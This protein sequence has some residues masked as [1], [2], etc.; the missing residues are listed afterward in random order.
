VK[1]SKRKVAV[2][3]LVAIVSSARLLRPPLISPEGFSQAVFDDRGNLL[4]LTLSHD[5]KYRLWTPL[6]QISPKVIEA[7]L[8]EEDQYFRWHWG[9]NPLALVRATFRTFLKRDRRLGASTITMQLVRL[10]Q[11]FGTKNAYGKIRQIFSALWLELNYSKDKILEAYLNLVP[12]GLNVEGVGAASFIYFQKPPEKLNLAE[13]LSLVAIPQNPTLR[14]P[15]AG[16][17]NPSYLKTRDRLFKRW[18]ERDGHTG[19]HEVLGISLRLPRDLP[20]RAPHFVDEAL[21][22]FPSRP[23]IYTT[24]NSSFQNLLERRISGYIEQKKGRGIKNA[25]AMLLDYRTMEVKS[26][27]GSANFHDAEISGQVNGT[28]ALR[29]PGS[30]LKPFIYGL[31]IDQGLIHPRTM[32]KDTPINFGPDNPE[33]SDHDFIGP[34]SAHAALN[35]SRNLPA[36]W[37]SNRLKTPSLFQF[38]TRAGIH[39]P[40]DEEY[41]GLSLTL[42]GAEMTMEDLVRLYAGLV[43]GGKI[44]SIKKVQGEEGDRP[45]SVLSTQAAFLVLD[46]LK[47]NP[48]P[49]TGSLMASR[50]LWTAWKTGTSNGARDA[51]TLAVFGPYVLGV[52]VGN[53]DGRPNTAFTGR[54]AAA[55]LAFQIIEGLRVISP[56]SLE[57]PK[58]PP[59]ISHVRVC[60]TSGGLPSPACRRTSESPFIPGKSPITTCDIHREVEISKLTGL[61]ICP[62]VAEPHEKKVFEFWSSDLARLFRL[63]GLPRTRPPKLDQRCQTSAA[64]SGSRPEI[65]SPLKHLSYVI[66][67][68]ANKHFEQ[69]NTIP[70]TATSDG[71]SRL[72][73]WFVNERFLGESRN[74]APLFWKAEPGAYVVRVVDE[75]GRSDARDLQVTVV[76]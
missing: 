32:L 64:Q 76:D 71:D 23:R 14:S 28:K 2:V 3:S 54:D 35:M 68:H 65:V 7:T 8:A 12:Y 11:G 55:P 48:Q 18:M 6:A 41:Y 17:P 24:L 43:N 19:D 49:N 57:A 25:A 1:W 72:L 53:F 31:A 37:L 73:Y 51:W 63:A 26:V 62:V 5:E 22:R 44:S 67:L 52:W 21:R 33:N 74:S 69:S 9:V 59:G 20:F 66:Q 15:K 29:S 45:I 10:T 47:D 42:G 61:R 30:T 50:P 13:A 39:Y 4:R 38:L 56:Q 70:F 60:S 46:M 58:E 16:T 40:R 27:V 36:L 34:V 75:Q